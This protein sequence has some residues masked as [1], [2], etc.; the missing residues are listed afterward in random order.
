MKDTKPIIIEKTKGDSNLILNQIKE[1]KLI[2][3]D[4]EYLIQLGKTLINE[5][6][7]FKIKEI[8]SDKK[9]FMINI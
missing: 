9:L 6:I 3:N 8:S 2:N 7:G 1:Y 5:R 4:K